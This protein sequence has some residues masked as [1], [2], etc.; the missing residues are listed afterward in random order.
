MKQRLEME[1]GSVA[2]AVQA[3]LERF[4]ADNAT[5]RLWAR[6][7]SLW[8]SE[9]VSEL[10]DRMGWL[11]LPAKMELE[12][13]RL[14]G[15]AHQVRQDG[16]RRVLLLG[17]GGSSLAPEVFQRT[18][19]NGDGFPALEVVDTTHPD[20]VA[21]VL[22]R[23]DT[24][25]TLVVVSS[26]SGGT[27][28]T[29]SLFRILWS[30]L[31]AA[32]DAPGRHFVAITD[33]G[34]ALEALGREHGFREIFGGLPEVGGRYSALSVF[35]LVP[36]ALIGLDID[37]VLGHARAM[38]VACATPDD[39][40]GLE[41]GAALGEL[42][43]A[44]RDKLTFL[45]S[46]GV[47]AFPDW[48]EQLVA[49]STGKDG[50][51]IVPVVGEAAVDADRYGSDRVFVELTLDD[52]PDEARSHLLGE[53]AAAGHPV[54]RV[55]LTSPFELG[56]EIFRWEVAV[57]M[58]S[59][60][61]GVNPFDQPDVQL[62]KDLARRALAGD[63]G[64]GRATPR[65]PAAEPASAV[66]SWLE[67]A[68]AGD[69]LAIQAFLEPREDTATALAGLRRRL[70]DA[71]GLATTL[72]WGPRFLHSTGQLH[73]GGPASCRCL[74][75]VDEPRQDLA[76]PEADATLRRLVR[77]QADGDLEALRRRGRQV[78]RVDLGSDPVGA[79]AD[80]G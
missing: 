20:A 45:T 22:A 32:S 68:V 76:V 33:P 18:F 40:P 39:N 29:L 15:F 38:A 48:L 12:S 73:K 75:L 19:G 59:A 44:G 47:A 43:A 7:P 51:G 49:E 71:T 27:V 58:A 79:L 78:L 21:G 23:L 61:L 54:L 28:E 80:L 72:G 70:E 17:M 63:D 74:Q 50:T 64:G 25:R 56:G 34:S 13:E 66:G 11:N 37:R 9:P 1:L 60:V 24:R 31:A 57:A 65:D 30:H 52:E 42:A 26:K 6:D 8:A 3:R 53:L 4:S 69:Y 14:L 36:A 77:G 62:A 10:A 55:T 67:A 16:Y 5:Y 46:P 35:G 41:L 2:R